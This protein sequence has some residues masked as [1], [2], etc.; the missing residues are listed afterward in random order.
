MSRPSR[1]KSFDYV[2]EYWYFV[3][4]CT[5]QRRRAFT[6]S[7]VVDAVRAEIFWTCEDRYFTS[8]I[9]LFMPDHV[10]FLVTG[11]MPNAEFGCV[12]ATR[13]EQPSPVGRNFS[14]ALQL[15]LCPTIESSAYV[16]EIPAITVI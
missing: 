5:D 2:G 10:H 13:W 14:S 3:T 15:K 12:R 6:D 7:E 1:L 4:C 11:E 9:L 8:R 16:F